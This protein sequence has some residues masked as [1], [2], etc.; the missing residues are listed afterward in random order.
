M[1]NN[2]FNNPI[3]IGIDHG[4]GNIKTAHCC[5][6]TGVAA[7]DKEPTFKSNLLVYEG[8]YYLIGEEHK[9]FISDK[10]TDS[11]YYI[12]TLA[13]VARELN[14]RKLTS[15]RVHLAAGLP[16][17][18]VSEQ[19]DSFNAY[20]LQKESADFTFKGVDYHIEFAGADIF[21]QGFSAVA[22]RL[23]EFK[24]INMLCDIGNGTMNVMYINECRPLAKSALPKSTAPISVCLRCE[25]I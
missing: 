2:T 12:L 1:S 23:R 6:K 16:L 21:P 8:R 20:L 10:M 13:A 24:G 22:D 11:D 14:I 7:Y 25:K 4:Y 19:K 17:T 5:F 9:E 15:A 3:I 18:W